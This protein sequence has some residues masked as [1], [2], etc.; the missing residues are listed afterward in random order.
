MLFLP[1]VVQ[2]VAEDLACPP[3]AFLIGVG[4][5]P[6]GHGLVAVAQLLRYTGD[7]RSVGNGNAGEGV[8]QLVRMQP[9]RVVPL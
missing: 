4:V 9:R 2:R 7:I 5:H 6:Q 8:P 1:G 3:D